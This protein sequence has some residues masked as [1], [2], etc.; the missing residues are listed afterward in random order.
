MGDA[1]LSLRFDRLMDDQD[2]LQMNAL[3][4][5]YLGDT[6]WEMIVRY[7][8]IIQK[9]NV[10]H[11][12]QRCVSLV[13]AHSQSEILRSLTDTL[14]DSEKEIVRRGR[15]AHAK[16]PVPKNQDPDEYA[17]AT[18]FEALLGYLYVTGKNDRISELTNH[19]KEVISNA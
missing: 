5:A 19:I 4:L 12:H 14:T 7:D 3:Q 1:G 10:R 13:N 16:H 17:M 6:V 18:G 11:M 2:A 8:L 15:N 9:L